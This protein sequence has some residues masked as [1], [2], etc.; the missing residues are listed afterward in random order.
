METL[1]LYSLYTVTVVK[2][3]EGLMVTVRLT[4]L[5]ENLVDMVTRRIR[6]GGN[7]RGMLVYPHK[8]DDVVKSS[9]R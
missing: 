9:D 5:G 8:G 7:E 4:G 2:L 1:P 3:A 6:E